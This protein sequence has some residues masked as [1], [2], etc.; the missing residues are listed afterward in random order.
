MDAPELLAVGDDRRGDGTDAGGS[1]HN[2]RIRR[3]GNRDTLRAARPDR[4][5]S[6]TRRKGL[7]T[8]NLSSCN[9]FRCSRS[10]LR[11]WAGGVV[12]AKPSGIGGGGGGEKRGVTTDGCQT[13]PMPGER[14][15][16]QTPP[17]TNA[18][19]GNQDIHSPS[20]PTS[21]QPAPAHYANIMLYYYGLYYISHQAARSG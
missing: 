21:P 4:L 18:L 14:N 2:F 10:L 1:G 11:V 15:R 6:P 9:S 16:Q 5:L 8:A 20:A 12:E 3:D 17:S 19:H 7:S 13:F